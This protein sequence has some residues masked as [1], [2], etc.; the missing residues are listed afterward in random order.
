M[1]V[2]FFDSVMDFDESNLTIW[3]ADQRGLFAGAS[4]SFQLICDR[5]G[6]KAGN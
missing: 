2:G 6:S 3:R 5:V 1:K 4:L